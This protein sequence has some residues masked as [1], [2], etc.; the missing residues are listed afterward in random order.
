MAGVIK[1]PRPAA[2]SN[3]TTGLPTSEIEIQ[4][5]VTT[6]GWSVSARLHSRRLLSIGLRIADDFVHLFLRGENK[7]L[8]LGQGDVE[9]VVPRSR[10]SKRQKGVEHLEEWLG[11]RT[12]VRRV[13]AFDG[14][15]SRRRCS[16]RV[17]IPHLVDGEDRSVAALRE[18]QLLNGKAARRD[19][20]L[21][22]AGK[23]RILDDALVN[24]SAQD[25]HLEAWR[26]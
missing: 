15:C 3:P 13:S 19:T 8:S 12:V 24:Q 5:T 14:C 2:A 21:L 9:R 11:R 17:I 4:N 23:G 18:N 26:Q 16:R 22:C 6:C 10:L 1:G 25:I 20:V 7:A